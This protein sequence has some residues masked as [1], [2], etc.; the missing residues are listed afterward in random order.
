MMAQGMPLLINVVIAIAMAATAIILHELAHGYVALALGDE[1]AWRAGRLSLNP[2]R[3][4]DRVG[5]LLLPGILLLT[6]LATVGRVLFMFGWAKPVPVDP[7]HFR[8]PRQGMALVALAGPM[9]NF[10]LAFIAAHAFRFPDHLTPYAAQLVVEFMTLNI[11]LGLFNLIPMPPLDGGRVAVGLLP[12]RLAVLWAGLERYG[13]MLVLLLI[14]VP[15][16]LGQAGVHTDP[17]GS[18]LNPALSWMTNSI[19]WLAGVRDA[20]A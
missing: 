11:V 7:T 6:Q 3:H 12:L 18:V 15:P 1:T 9:M 4:V 19:L 20:G 14:A 16:L 8:Y 13:I 5:T 2:V 17:L 10:S